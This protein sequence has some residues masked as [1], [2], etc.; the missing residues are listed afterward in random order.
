MQK[1][2]SSARLGTEPVG[3][4]L[5]EMAIPTV[6]A[7]MVNLLYNI[8][9]RIYVGHIPETGALALAGL[10]V[11]FPITMLV[12][13]FASLV[14]GGG[15]ARAS[16]ALGKGD[17]ELAQKI[18]NNC[19]T[20]LL[21]LSAALMAV[22]LPLRDT[23]LMAFGASENTLPYASGYIFIYLL[24]TVF[25]QLT[26]GLN[27]FITN[28]GFSK[29]SMV[30][31][32]IGAALNI[33]LDP[34]LIYGFHMGVQG[35]ALATILSQGVSA[36]W[37]VCFLNGK[38][39][40]LHVRLRDMGLNWQVLSPVLGLG[41]S[42]FVMQSTECLVQLAFNNGMQKYGDDRYVALMSICFSL[43]QIV[44]LPVSGFGQGAQ[45]L[46][47][48]NYGAG[49]YDRVRQTFWKMLKTL[50]Y[51]VG[52]CRCGTVPG[53]VHAHVYFRPGTDSDG[54][55]LRAAVPG[56]AFCHRAAGIL[57]AD[58]DG[59]GT[60][61]DFHVPG[62]EPQA[63]SAAAPGADSA[64][65]GRFGS[66]GPSAGGAGKRFPGLLHHLRHLPLAQQKASAQTAIGLKRVE[67][68]VHSGKN[69]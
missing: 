56:G 50:L 44:W 25:V 34:I 16:I 49:R 35:A 17:G 66:V 20:L 43:T 22:F 37:V 38:K 23:I 59:P 60:G 14:G 24:G 1:M 12:S 62:H 27:V 9:D 3:K 6:L 36:V 18:L 33:C 53:A 52:H 2:Q 31:V 19:V 7:Q 4:L 21:I 68:L 47:G 5:W 48:Y 32:C 57:S 26:L 69:V 13:A 58:A 55:A 28:Q 40:G 61:E 45:P 8:V 51:P 39:S 30:T 15:A 46:V 10:G 67:K 64:P 65:G 63:D 41:L 11:T 54:Q 42:P 29:M